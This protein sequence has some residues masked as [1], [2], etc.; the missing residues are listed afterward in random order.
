MTISGRLTT[1]E[2]KLASDKGVTITVVYEHP[3][4]P[5]TWLDEYGNELDS[6]PE[7]DLVIKVSYEGDYIK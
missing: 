4:K 7:S 3:D 5:N 2:K 1:L 6:L